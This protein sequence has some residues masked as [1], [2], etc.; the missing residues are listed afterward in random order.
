MSRAIY[1]TDFD[2][3]RL[4]KLI[5]EEK[6]FNPNRKDRFRNLEQ[7]LDRA[8]VVLSTK[9][10]CDVVT[11]NSKVLLRNV[12][13]GEEMTYSLVFPVDA[14]LTEGKISVLAPV[15][16][17][18]LGYRVGDVVD[19]KIPDGVIKLKVEKIIYQPEAVGNYDL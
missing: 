3:K 10:P 7:E 2:Q 6:E 9:I 17:A 8:Q 4:Q 15:G 14:D 11:M 16:T 19:W 13:S 1:I 12:D 5:D 18:I